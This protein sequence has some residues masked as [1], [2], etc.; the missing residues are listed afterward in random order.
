VLLRKSFLVSGVYTLF[1]MSSSCG[2]SG[3]AT[4]GNSPEADPGLRP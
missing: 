2:V 3:C 4:S 1:V